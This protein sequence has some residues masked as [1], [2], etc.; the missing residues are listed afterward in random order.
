VEDKARN[1]EKV[2]DLPGQV[3]SNRY[4][5]YPEKLDKYNATTNPNCDL[6][7]LRTRIDQFFDN[8]YAN[9]NDAYNGQAQAL[10]PIF[11]V[12]RASRCWINAANSQSAPGSTPNDPDF[13]RPWDAKLDPSCTSDCETWF[14]RFL[15]EFASEYN[16]RYPNRQFWVE[17]GNEPDCRTTLG[18]GT[19]YVCYYSTSSNNQHILDYAEILRHSYEVIHEDVYQGAEDKAIVLTGGLAV[20]PMRDQSG[21]NGFT[22]VF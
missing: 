13:V 1:Q 14:G 2:D 6:G 3:N 9:Y 5:I 10:H 22:W 21:E 20:E 19:N 7:Q 15:Y 18:S 16:N 17:L 4:Q 8:E 11:L 12:I